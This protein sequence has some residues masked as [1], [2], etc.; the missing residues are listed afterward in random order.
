MGRQRRK[1]ATVMRDGGVAPP[2]ENQ[3]ERRRHR[4]TG[5]VAGG[6]MAMRSGGTRPTSEA[7]QRRELPNLSF[8]VDIE[9][10]G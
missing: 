8:G 7:G 1:R 2:S 4:G 9:G 3:A 5:G 6:S 10:I